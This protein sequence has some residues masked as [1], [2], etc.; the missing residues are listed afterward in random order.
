VNLYT[1]KK[2]CLLY[3]ARV[4]VLLR[5]LRYLLD[6]H[7]SHAR[8]CE[9]W[10]QVDNIDIPGVVILF[11]PGKENGRE[12]I[13][14]QHICSCISQLK[15]MVVSIKLRGLECITVDRCLCIVIRY[16]I[17]SS[18]YYIIL[19]SFDF[20]I[21]RFWVKLSKLVYTDKWRMSWLIRNDFANFVYCFK[22]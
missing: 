17:R 4:S 19:N 22:N 12:S 1:Y 7:D 18:L 9:G 10:N 15:I 6:T 21:N 5:N 8:V 3:W 11:L 2:L 14:R 20:S 16:T 13:C